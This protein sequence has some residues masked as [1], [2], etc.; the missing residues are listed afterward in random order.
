[1]NAK[2]VFVLCMLREKERESNMKAESL[3]VLRMKR[4]EVKKWINQ[5]RIAS[6]IN[7]PGRH[8]R[9]SSHSPKAPRELQRR[10]TNR[11]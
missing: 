5:G 3:F 2:N 7:Q 1:M 8:I 4:N 9:T 11:Y 10:V 6:K